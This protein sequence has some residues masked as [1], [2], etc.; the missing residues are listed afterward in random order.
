M[1]ERRRQL[2][3][4]G[5]QREGERL[6]NGEEKDR[7]V[8]R[9]EER[10]DIRVVVRDIDVEQADLMHQQRRDA[11]Q[12]REKSGNR[13]SRRFFFALL[14]ALGVLHLHPA[15]LQVHRLRRGRFLL[16]L[17]LQRLFL[18][19]KN[20]DFFEKT[21]LAV[22]RRQQRHVMLQERLSLLHRSVQLPPHPSQPFHQ[23][24]DQFRGF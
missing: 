17:A 10:Q 13:T 24:L 14:A 15:N 20:R 11:L 21:Q 5:K 22:Q 19:G 23:L 7:V 3:E 16:H 6:G 2:D 1:S 18:N 12:H 4:K 9:R 8:D